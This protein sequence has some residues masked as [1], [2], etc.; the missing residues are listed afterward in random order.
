MGKPYSLVLLGT[1]TE[2]DDSN[3]ADVALSDQE[4]AQMDRLFP[5]GVAAGSNRPTIVQDIEAGR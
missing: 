3:P 5:I 4:I 2:L 1:R